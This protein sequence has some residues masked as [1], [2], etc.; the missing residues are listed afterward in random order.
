MFKD[1]GE[2]LL[3]IQLEFSIFMCF[4]TYL[5]FAMKL[6]NEKIERSI[7]RM[8]RLTEKQN[9]LSGMWLSIQGI[10]TQCKMK[11]ILF[12]RLIVDKWFLLENNVKI[13]SHWDAN[14][15]FQYKALHFKEENFEQVMCN[16]FEWCF[17]TPK[18][19]FCFLPLKML[20]DFCKIQ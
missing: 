8:S 19:T 7:P 14:W 15:L 20:C 17:T 4:S 12:I 2:S 1:F 18:C 11:C 9:I 3:L 16:H 5:V 10:I 6:F 13:E